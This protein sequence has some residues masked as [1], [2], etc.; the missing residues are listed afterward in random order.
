MLHELVP[1]MAINIQSHVKKSMIITEYLF[2]WQI[3][4]KKTAGCSLLYEIWYF[5]VFFVVSWTFIPHLSIFHLT[6]A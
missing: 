3:M 2:K 1:M 6:K 4:N 5:A